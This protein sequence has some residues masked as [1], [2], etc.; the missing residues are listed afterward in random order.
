MSFVFVSYPRL[1]RAGVLALV[2]HLEAQGLPLYWDQ[3]LQVGDWKEQLLTRLPEAAAM[4]VLVT[5]DVVNRGGDSWVRREIEIAIELKKK[6]ILPVL[7]GGIGLGAELDPLL[8]RFQQIEAADIPEL[9]DSKGFDSHV[10]TLK[11]LVAG[12]IP[13]TPAPSPATMGGGVWP[14]TGE[15]L[16]ARQSLLLTVTMLEGELPFLVSD[17]A[18]QLEARIAKGLREE[19]EDERAARPRHLGTTSLSEE[20]A[21]I[22]AERRRVV[23]GH[24]AQQEVIR[25][26]DPNKRARVLEHIWQERPTVR[27]TLVDW[28]DD[29]TGRQDDP[30][31]RDLLR[32]MLR[33]LLHLAQVDLRGLHHE[34]L[35]TWMRRPLTEL[36][37]LLTS[38]ALAAAWNI[39]ENRD[40]VR[41]ILLDLRS[42][43]SMG[44]GFVSQLSREAGM[45]VAL[46]PFGERAP[47]QA[48]ETLRALAPHLK[49]GRGGNTVLRLRVQESPLLRGAKH[50]RDD[51]EDA[52]EDEAYEDTAA[53]T[54]EVAEEMP[55][56]DPLVLEDK[57]AEPDTDDAPLSRGEGEHAEASEG[58]PT[59]TFLKS[60]GAWIDEKIAR[61]DTRGLMDRQ[62]ALWVFLSAFERMPLYKA[63][64]PDRLTLEELETDVA[65]WSPDI[66]DAVLRAMV[67]AAVARPRRGSG[68][69]AF[70]HLQHVLRLFAAERA[71]SPYRVDGA[72]DP[73]LQFAATLHARIEAR[74]PGR[75]SIVLRG[76]GRFLSAGERRF[77][78]GLPSKTEVSQ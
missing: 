34:L 16:L 75:G 20:L 52:D 67:R 30:T 56:S 15:N 76:S 17:A 31:A 14:V 1:H 24:H 77:I 21:E 36:Q 65:T 23:A 33:S 51:A 8:S 46:G 40:L 27:K 22:G 61:D 32:S 62:A 73:Y 78:Q 55:A 12:E 66:R 69:L 37:L 35:S 68:Y 3:Q 45:Y 57:P 28:I 43:R 50:V 19:T 44:D 53:V 72:D 4:I 64:A 39:H 49:V 18:T 7:L 5:E 25:F 54:A 13:E 71:A 9:L 48:V 42:G 11:S 6:N 29:L 58:L 41:E 63:S 70:R 10:E 47:E 74:S 2:Q 26:K 60:L 38:Y 59:A